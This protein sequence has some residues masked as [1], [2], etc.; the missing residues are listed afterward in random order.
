M[1]KKS[2]NFLYNLERKW[3]RY[4]IPNLTMYMIG[5]YVV[6][7]LLILIT[8]GQAYA[9][10]C[11]EMNSV[12]HGQVWRLFTFLLIP[13]NISIL[14]F[15]TLI[16]YAS[17][18]RTLEQAWGT[19]YYNVYIFSGIIFT[20]LGNVL[21]YII[22]WLTSGPTIVIGTNYYILLSMFLAY[23][24][25]FPDA[26]VLAMFI[27]PIKVK[28]MAYAYYALMA[29]QLYG[30]FSE[31]INKKNISEWGTV[32]SIVMSLMNFFIFYY[33]TRRRTQPSFKQKMKKKAYQKKV[34]RVNPQGS[35]IHRCSVCGATSEEHPELEFRFCSK[36]NGNYEYC[37]NHLFTHE[38]VK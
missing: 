16:F 24:M 5:L 2:G 12:F 15:I 23:A 3:G 34:K 31:I 7:L 6:G 14:V 27:I 26:E 30:C 32:A 8:N 17:I 20:I 33:L 38:H 11:L 4:A 13:P 29:Y 18:G 9:T 28:W 19:F 22:V 21:A 1:G 37:Q 35:S 25:L 10:L 36:C